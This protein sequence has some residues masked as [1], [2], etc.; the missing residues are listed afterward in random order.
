MVVVGDCI[1]AVDL[2]NSSI[3]YIPKQGAN[4][5]SVLAISSDIGITD[6]EEHCWLDFHFDAG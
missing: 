5:P 4:N 2:D 6:A 1:T 3:P